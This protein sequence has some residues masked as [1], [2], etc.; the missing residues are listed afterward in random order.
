MNEALQRLLNTVAQ[1]RTPEGCPW[2]REQ[3]PQTLCPYILE[4]S[5]ELVAAIESG[6]EQDVLEELG[7]VLLQVVLQ[8]QIY[9][10][11]GAFDFAQVCDRINEKLI[12]RHPH[13]FSAVQVS[14][15]AEVVQ[16]WEAIK[17]LEKPPQTLSDKLSLLPKDLSS[18][19]ACHKISRKVAQVGFEWPDL[20]GVLAKVHE[21][22]DELEHALAEESPARQAEELGDLLFS[23]VNVARWQGIDSDTALRQTNRRFLGRFRQV[24]QLATQPLTA[25]TPAQLEELWQQAKRLTQ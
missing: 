9:Q 3:T 10:E 4:E 24:E 13:V 12:H 19:A 5:A 16:N 25:Y 14:T 15:S 2:D 21:E 6:V 20:T 1:L 22:L 8:A 23:V 7:D 18:L 11:Q 17:A